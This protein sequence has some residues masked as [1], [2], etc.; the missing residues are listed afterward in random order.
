MPQD[1][2]P[3]D[4]MRKM[5]EFR[6]TA[7]VALGGNQP[8]RAGAPAQTLVKAI[9][10]L[11]ATGLRVVAVSRFFNT[12][13]FPAGAGPDFVNAAILIAGEA[14]PTR[15]LARLHKIEASFGRQRDRRWGARTLDLDL[16]GLGD[17]VRPDAGTFRAWRDLPVEL[18]VRQAPGQ[19]ILPHPRLQDRAF[20]L[21]PLA[22]IA[23]GWRHPVTG[24][25]VVQM[26]AALPAQA[27][28]EVVPI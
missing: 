4:F 21:V 16:I 17:A 24:V 1:S 7:L 22:D 8:S 2:F 20:V 6:S 11:A 12:A 26:C 23:P 25:T 9:K 19:L 15:L 28:R 5:P 13:C 14:E 10:S 3:Y 18:Q 27:R